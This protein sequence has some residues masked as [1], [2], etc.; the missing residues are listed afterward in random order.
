[1]PP[2]E[3]QGRVELAGELVSSSARQEHPEVAARA[4]TE[5]DARTSR[6]LQEVQGRAGAVSQGEARGALGLRCVG[7]DARG[8]ADLQGR[9]KGAGAGHGPVQ[10]ERPSEEGIGRRSDRGE[11][12]ER[13]ADP[14]RVDS[15]EGRVRSL[16]VRPARVRL[17]RVRPARVR[18][19]CVPS[20]RRRS[21]GDRSTLAR[22]EGPTT[23]GRR[24]RSPST[25][26]V[27]PNSDVPRRSA[28]TFASRSAPSAGAVSTASATTR[29]RAS[30]SAAQS[31]SLSVFVVE[32]PLAS[33]NDSFARYRSSEMVICT[34]MDRP[35]PGMA[36]DGPTR[37]RR[38][39]T[40][41]LCDGHVSGAR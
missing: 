36:C 39:C 9:S 7:R 22:S 11:A 33:T 1:M 4:A 10:R 37:D 35:A 14:R 19:L 41:S 12:S 21:A 2:S 17:L 29:A 13:D 27:T 32:R 40:K 16:C 20:A 18:S 3:A 25:P 5:H 8:P 15:P 26:A 28:F 23:K 6:P 24:S 34:S 31:R 30:T 38:R